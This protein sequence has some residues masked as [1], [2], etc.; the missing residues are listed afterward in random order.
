MD[1][2]VE[3]GATAYLLMWLVRTFLVQGQCS[4]GRINNPSCIKKQIDN[5]P[6]K[7]YSQ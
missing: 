1:E 2:V 7:A 3:V 4:F 6:V 5:N